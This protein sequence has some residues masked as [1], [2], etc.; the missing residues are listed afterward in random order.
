MKKIYS[1]ISLVALAAV[2]AGCAKELV[3]PED[4]MANSNKQEQVINGELTVQ[5]AVPASA[6][7]KTVLGTKDGSTYPVYWSP[8]DVITLNGTAATEFTPSDDNTSATAKF[9]LTSLTAPYNF[10]YGGVSGKGDQ[11]SYPATQNYV[12][13]GFDPVAMPMYA[14][15]TDLKGNVAFSHVGSLLRFSFTGENKITSITLTAVDKDK[16][17]SGNFTIGTSNGVLDGTLTPVSG[18]SSL[19]YSFGEDKQLSET[20]FIFYIAVPAGTYPGGISLEVYDNEA[21]HMTVKVMQENATIA[22][23]KVREFENVVYEPQKE[24]NLIQINSDATLQQFATRVK[25][26]E[27]YLNARVS[28]DFTATS[29]W[30]PVEDY[31]GIF[32]GNGKTISGLDQPLF[33]NLGGAVRNLILNSNITATDADERSWGMFARTIVPSTEVDDVAGLYNCTAKGTL[34]F[35][36]SSALSGDSQIGGLVGNN[37]GG[38]IDNCTNEADVTM[39]DNGQTNSGQFSLGGIIGRTQKGG[40]LSTQGEITS[41]TNNGAVT[42]NAKFSENAYI[43][44]VLGYQVDK[45]EYIS[46]C[47]NNGLVKV[48]STFSTA[49]A[50]QLGGVVG[51]GKGLIESC[52]NGTNGAV[53]SEEGSTAGTYICQGGVVGRLNRNTDDTYS[54]LTNAGN[55][56]V[57]AAG[58]STGAYVGGMVGRCDE[59]ASLSDCTNTGG[60]IEFNGATS[61]CPI[62]IGGIVG[63]SKGRVVSC[64]N[65]TAI[66]FNTDYRLNTTGKYLSIGGVVGR[67]DADVEISNNTN[68]AAVTFDGYVT[69]YM[70]LGG[71]VGYCSG[72]I[73]GGENRGTVSYTGKSTA[74]NVPIGGIAGRTP[75]SKTG[76]RITGV[77][78]RGEIIINSASQEKKDFYVGGV[79]GHHQS[80]NLSAVNAG[81]INVTSLKCDNLKLG[82]LVGENEGAISAGSNNAES[83]DITLSGLSINHYLYI[84]GVTGYGKETVTANN[85]GDVTLSEDCSSTKTMH[86]GGIVG[87]GHAPLVSCTNTGAVTNGCSMEKVG[88]YLQLGGVVGYNDGDSPL[89]DCH[90]TGAV[91]NTG[92]SAGYLYI[93][94]ITSETDANLENCSNAGN[95]SN[96]G[97]QADGCPICIGGVA[98]VNGGK[99]FTSCLSNTG[100][101]SDESNSTDIR[102][103]GVA[104]YVYGSSAALMDRCINSSEVFVSNEGEFSLENHI[105]IGGI[106]GKGSPIIFTSCENKGYIRVDTYGETN[107]GG[108]IAGGIFGDNQS[109]EVYLNDCYNC[110]NSNTIET[111]FKTSVTTDPGPQ[112]HEIGGIAGRIL[113]SG[114]TCETIGEIK[115]C[116]NTG[117]LCDVSNRGYLGG[118]VGELQEGSIIDCTN[119]NIVEFAYNAVQNVHIAVGGIVGNAWGKAKNITGCTNSGG[120]IAVTNNAVDRGNYIGGI[121][122]WAESESEVSECENTGNVT[123]NTCANS[124]K[125]VAMAG[126][127]IGYKES[128][129]KD[130]GNINRGDVTSLAR[131]TRAGA[132]GGV[133]GVLRYG[134]IESCY[135]YGTIEAGEKAS[136]NGWGDT[137]AVYVNGRAGSIVGFYGTKAMGTYKKCEGTVTKCY[138]GGAVQ[139]KHTNG[140][141]RTIT[142]DNYGGNIVGE[143]NDPTDCFFAGN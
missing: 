49:K 82:G 34:T 18:N 109:S 78:N 131:N 51:M 32:D 40:D 124:S 95:V 135:N 20:P 47:V 1:Y 84:G 43:G 120:V 69:G 90:N 58:A 17:L 6:Q 101:I 7:T 4:Q 85:A 2:S 100:K 136:D 125:P 140:E 24:A 53:T 108:V 61:T 37:R 119:A 31:K 98:G 19:L 103:G 110:V 76:D 139:G 56:N 28:A 75:G 63:Q 115:E 71:I 45:K 35:T 67:Q 77:T 99:N 81:K 44:G 142:A 29:A 138:V 80:A 27:Y 72:P 70:V 30:T 133:V 107:I 46:G 16:S 62:H 127:I 15:V 64:T 117:Y 93:G 86:I 48:T 68:T 33:D 137:N 141:V 74:Q 9:K 132:A 38:V 118:I 102:I 113:E 87:S 59:G 26:G 11:V 14:S 23:G 60:K 55:I 89:T 41:C 79:V 121:V 65:A 73:S 97:A 3:N 83:G 22:A 42:C 122:G 25:E 111:Y 105:R 10:L 104:G 126:G 52:T 5:L 96:S 143:G 106:V 130:S 66:L 134:I 88:E 92:N 13:D 114:A 129:S 94:G 39:G 116:S 128:T 8:E 57:G 21:G 12:A 54:G 123:C 91:T 50:L 112:L 36:P